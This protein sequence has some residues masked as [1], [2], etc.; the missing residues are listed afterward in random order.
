MVLP[1]WSMPSFYSN[2]DPMDVEV[3]SRGAK[4]HYHEFVDAILGEDETGTPFS[5]ACPVTECVLV[6]VVAGAF[7]D[8][9]L[10]WDSRA[11]RFA[12]DEANA[13]V[14]KTYREGR[15]PV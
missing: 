2:G 6:G 3:V 5:F 7:R 15:A 9:E 14:R 1:H 12:D 11:L 13:L 4:N 10:S 8:R